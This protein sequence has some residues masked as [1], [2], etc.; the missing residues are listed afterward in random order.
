TGSSVMF[1]DYA[2]DQ[3]RRRKQVFMAD[4]RAKLDD[5]LRFNERGVLPDSGKVSRETADAHAQGE[6]EGFSLLRREE[7]E[8]RAERD[9]IEGVDHAAKNRDPKN[10]PPQS[11][12]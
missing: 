2:E 11:E 4:W 3:A 12:D 1:L 5:F 8:A 7:L 10:R 6:Y 9:L